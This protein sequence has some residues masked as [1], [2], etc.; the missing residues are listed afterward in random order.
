MTWTVRFD[1]KALKQLGKVPRADQKRISN[2]LKNRVARFE[3]PRDAGDPLHG[4]FQGYWKY[5]V[6][7]YRVIV[8]IQDDELIVLVIRIGHRREVY[9]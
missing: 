8:D 5:R 6:G 4:Q 1:R 7:N 9:R 3:N 2:Y